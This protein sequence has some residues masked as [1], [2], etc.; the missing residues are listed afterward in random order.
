M[1]RAVEPTTRQPGWISLLAIVPLLL[2]LAGG[3]V[4]TFTQALSLHTPA[5]Q[6]GGPGLDAFRIALA[7]PDLGRNLVFSLTVAT[8]SA[9]SSV[10][11]GTLLAYLLWRLPGGFRRWGSAFALPLILPH[12]AVGFLVITWFGQTGFVA[13]MLEQV[14]LAGFYRSPL[15]RGDGAGVIVAY[16]YKSAP[17]VLFLVLPVL[18]K[19]SPGYLQ[20]ARM[21]GAGEVRGFITVILPRLL[22]AVGASWVILFV[23]SFGAYDLPFIVGE[24]SPRMISLYLYRLYFARPIAERPVA[25]ALLTLVCL[26]GITMV[27][28]YAR[29]VSRLEERERR[30]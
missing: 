30:L 5:L 3:L 10:I 7:L 6:T 21:L 12:V 15:F 13:A 8:I 23:Y 22:P 9:T 14:G 25:A 19:I 1:F 27:V 20:T 2:L 4:F 26:M 18:R 24:S 17:F 28:I 11:A 29:L 16:L